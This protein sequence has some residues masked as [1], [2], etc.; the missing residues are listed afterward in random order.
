VPRTT[1]TGIDDGLESDLP[2]GPALFGPALFEPALFGFDPDLAAGLVGL[3]DAVRPLAVLV[4]ERA[5]DRERAVGSADVR[6]A[7]VPP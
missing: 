5:P 7:T 3:D 4:A 1:R 6:G 2:F